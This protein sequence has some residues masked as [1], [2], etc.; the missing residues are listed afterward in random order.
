LEDHKRMMSLS[1]R[2]VR[3]A[4]REGRWAGPTAGM[5]PGFVQANLVI[6]PLDWAF[7]FLLFCQRNPRPCPLLE[8]TE[9]GDWEPRGLAEGADL[10]SDLPRYR[11][12]REG[13]LT[14][15]PSDIRTL[16]RED[17][18]SFLIGCS[19]TFEGALLEAGLPVRHIEMG[20]N[21]PM[22][23]TS[24]ACRPAGRLKGPMVMTMR[25]IPAPMVARAVTTTSLFPAV[26]GAPLHIGEPGAIG[27]KDL[28]RPDHGDAVEIRE[29]EVPVFWGCGV[30]PQAAMVASKPPFAVTH[31]PG[32]MFVSDKKNV[33]YSIF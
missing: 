21:V 26:H 4:V 31:A 10:R 18:V 17:L 30:T 33:D 22:Y 11:V 1:P 13:V 19:F 2:E 7:D 29:G 20:V 28:S 27:I 23:V 12:Y 14:E 3:Q 8:V 16:W 24:V 5:A 15:E 25:P 6:L 32:H 9:P